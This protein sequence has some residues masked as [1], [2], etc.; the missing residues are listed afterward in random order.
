[1]ELDLASEL[2][3]YPIEQEAQEIQPE[4]QVQETPQVTEPIQTT[5]IIEEKPVYN[6]PFI[7]S[8]LKAKETPGFDVDKYIDSYKEGKSVSTMDSDNG[9][10]Y[11]YQQLKTE[12]GE[13]QYTD[14]DINTYLEKITPI[15]K[16]EKWNSV[17]GTLEE[18]TKNTYKQSTEEYKKTLTDFYGKTQENTNAYLT[19][20]YDTKAKNSEIAGLP[21]A[22]GDKKEFQQYFSELMQINTESEPLTVVPRKIHDLLNDNEMLY[23]VLYIYNQMKKGALQKHIANLRD[24]TSKQVLDKMGVNPRS[25]SGH[26]SNPIRPPKPEDFI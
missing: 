13:R 22:E 18:Q 11:Y 3:G 2:A 7:E 12:N 26:M 8:Y 10:K 15:E 16:N 5:P 4:V 20:L 19:Q 14:E 21:Y 24:E 1:M 9:L 25:V 23:D 17:K 6:D